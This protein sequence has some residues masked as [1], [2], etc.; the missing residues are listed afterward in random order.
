MS[1]NSL[2]RKKALAHISTPDQLTEHLK[3]TG[4]GLWTLLA[5]IGAV[6]LGFAVWGF[7]GRIDETVNVTG[8]VLAMEGQPLAVYS[9]LPIDKAR[10][11]SVGMPVE[12]SPTYAAVETYGFINGQV[13]SVGDS[14]LTSQQ[15]TEQLGSAADLVDLPDGNLIQVVIDFDVDETGALS[16]SRPEGHSVNV[17]VGT[18]CTLSIVTAE[19]RPL[20]L[21]FR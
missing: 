10:L 9:Y 13:A 16:W 5:G 1:D 19:R 8:T 15:I 20:D 2:F 14:P 6:V 17:L 11:L 7:F 18:T 3:V 12:I 21:L 4:I